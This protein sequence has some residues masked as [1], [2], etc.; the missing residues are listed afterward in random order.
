MKVK[1]DSRAQ[2]SPA[3]VHRRPSGGIS[4]ETVFGFP[5]EA[6]QF[7]VL[8]SN[9]TTDF[10]CPRAEEE[11]GLVDPR[12]TRHLRRVASRAEVRGRQAAVQQSATVHYSS[13]AQGMSGTCVEPVTSESCSSLFVDDSFSASPVDILSLQ[14]A[15]PVHYTLGTGDIVGDAMYG[16]DVN[17][18]ACTVENCNKRISNAGPDW[19][20]GRPGHTPTRRILA[21]EKLL[22]D[23]YAGQDWSAGRPGNKPFGASSVAC[24]SHN[25][26]C[27]GPYGAAFEQPHHTGPNTCEETYAMTS[28]TS[29]L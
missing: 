1:S 5:L 6:N 10:Q 11:M 20:A 26:A 23:S 24:P 22:E 2:H 25:T 27:I 15:G 18:V 16:K 17:D 3:S 14:S 19:S 8:E 9:Q 4:E 12:T 7:N 29:G 28:S 13:D 21:C